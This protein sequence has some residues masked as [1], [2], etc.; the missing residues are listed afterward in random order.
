MNLRSAIRVGFKNVADKLGGL[1]KDIAGSIIGDQSLHEEGL[2][3]L[4]QAHVEPEVA[5][6][7][8]EDDRRRQDGV[9]RR[10]RKL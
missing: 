8:A 7:E 2:A 1:A 10:I 9:L 6:I 5:A 3:Q 4:D